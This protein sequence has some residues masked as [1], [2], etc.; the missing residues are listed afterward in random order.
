MHKQGYF[1]TEG[2]CCLIPVPIHSV[3]SEIPLRSGLE[4]CLF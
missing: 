2:S 1:F 4:S 3:T